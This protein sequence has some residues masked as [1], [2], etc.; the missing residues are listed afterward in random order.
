MRIDAHQHFWHYDDARHDWITDEMGALR[1]DFLPEHLRPELAAAGMDATVAVQVDQTEDETRFLLDLAER[2]AEI[3]GVVGWIDLRAQNIAER[4]EQFAQNK[5]LRGF[6][7]IAQSEADDCFLIRDGFVRG[8]SHLARFDFTYDILIYPRQL[9]AAIELVRR[10]P[11]QR[12]VVDHMAKPLIRSRQMEPWVAQMRTIARLENVFC[13]VSGLVTEADWRAWQPANFQPYLDVIFESFG[14]DRLMFGS[15]WP[16]C[17]LA[18][19][20]AQVKQLIAD[21]ASSDRDKLF[22]RNAAAFYGLAAQ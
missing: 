14:T 12:F 21:Y 15:D 6:R 11:E 2:H 3:A 13:K 22:G 19:S 5:K 16:V 8:I 1:R 4:L 7:H 18:A 9:P 17:L 10:F 20:Y